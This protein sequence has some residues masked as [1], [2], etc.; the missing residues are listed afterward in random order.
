M[1]SYDLALG[2]P[3]L[4]FISLSTLAGPFS[5]KPQSPCQEHEFLQ[6]EVGF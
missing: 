3:W 6:D 5:F 2:A 4:S 1:A